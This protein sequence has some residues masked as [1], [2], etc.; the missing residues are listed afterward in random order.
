MYIHN[1]YAPVKAEERALFFEQLLS[2]NFDSASTHLVIGDFNTP[3]NPAVDA[4]SGA[5]RHESN[6]LACLEW[7]SQLGVVDAWRIQHPTENVFTGPLPRKYRLDYICMSEQ[8][9]NMVFK[10]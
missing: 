8:L 2:Y 1:V 6:R 3:L 7:L 4:S 10:D 5:I 9:F